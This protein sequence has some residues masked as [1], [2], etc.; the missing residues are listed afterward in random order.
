MASEK[1]DLRPQRVLVV[2]TDRIGDVL[3][4]TPVI[5]NL[6]RAYPDAHLAF[7]VSPQSREVLEGNPELNEIILDDVEGKDGGLRGML[8]QVRSIRTKRFD[9]V[10]VLHP[11]L[12][13]AL[14]LFLSGIPDRIGT[15][16]R[17][18]SLLFNRRVR[19]HR[20]YAQKHEL[21]YNL[22]LLKPLGVHPEAVA[23]RVYLGQKDRDFGEKL[24]QQ[25]AIS[26]VPFAIIHPGSRGSAR[27]WPLEN[28][29]ALGDRIQEELGLKV[30][31][32][33]G[34]DEEAL[35]NQLVGSMKSKA[36]SIA[37]RTTLKQLGAVIE[38]A[39]AFISNSTGAM[40]VAAGVGIP[41]LAF[42]PPIRASSS[43][44]WGPW[45]RGHIILQ[46]D[47]PVC[48][49]CRPEK[50]QFG[51]CMAR[52]T[53]EEACRKLCALLGG[54]AASAGSKPADRSRADEA[55]SP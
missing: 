7:L 20:K 52:I 40:H 32:T 48:K 45:G 31:V 14:M 24:L 3:L 4:S 39:R 30:L 55:P 15:G 25:Y 42:F 17:A 1:A 28:F 6:R 49:K 16:Y 47:V 29:A 44:R 13:L 37:G 22:S 21:E 5:S 27:D 8:N 46:P 41:V 2:R 50:C 34:K 26:H 12:R 23:P 51:D 18:Y 53:V 38:Q 11:G 33:G 19:E 54:R 43:K 9:A 35:A 36:E 10:V